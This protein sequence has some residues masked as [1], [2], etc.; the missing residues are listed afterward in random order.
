MQKIQIFRNLRY[1]RTNKG[2]DQCGQEKAGQFFAI[3]ADI[4]YGRPLIT[5]DIKETLFVVD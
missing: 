5:T 4:F 3:C 1:V 2:V